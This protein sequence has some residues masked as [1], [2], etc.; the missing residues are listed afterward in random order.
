MRISS[1]SPKRFSGLSQKGLHADPILR[2]SVTELL[3]KFKTD[4]LNK[5]CDNLLLIPQDLMLPGMAKFSSILNCSCVK[6]EQAFVDDFEKLCTFAHIHEFFLVAA[7]V[8]IFYKR[9]SNF[10]YQATL[11]INPRETC[12][13]CFEQDTLQKNFSKLL[14][15]QSCHNINTGQGNVLFNPE[16]TV[17]PIFYLLLIFFTT[18]TYLGKTSQPF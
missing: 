5:I 13:L 4:T 14:H 7:A 3:T 10:R 12:I 18:E 1:Y 2:K 8:L 6:G 15:S 11:S 17:V 16:T 9:Q